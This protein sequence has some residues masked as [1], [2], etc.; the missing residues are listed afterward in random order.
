MLSPLSPSLS[1]TFLSCEVAIISPIV[2]TFSC[3]LPRE[4]VANGAP[5]YERVSSDYMRVRQNLQRSI[6][7]HIQHMW[8][9]Q[10]AVLRPEY[11]QFRY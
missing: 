1:H 10:L 6:L 4:V 9:L 3:W 5:A 7:Q 8:N 11:H 2:K